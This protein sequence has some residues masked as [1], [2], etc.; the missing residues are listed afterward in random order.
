MK[1][2][3]YIVSF[4]L[5]TSCSMNDRHKIQASLQYQLEYYPASRL[6]D[7]YKNFFQDFYGPGHLVENPQASLDYLKDELEEVGGCT[8]NKPVE[9][10]GYKNRFVRVDLCLIKNGRISFEEFSEL[11]LESARSFKI[12]NFESWEAEWKKILTEI[13]ELK[14]DIPGFQQDKVLLNEM[15]QRGEYVVHHSKEYIR[16]Y[17]PHYRIV[18]KDLLRDYS[19]AGK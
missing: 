14:V 3:L 15:L 2:T 11:F 18:R 17:D 16:E 6:T 8:M 7:I 12:P 10:T 9:E 13:E 5:I 4:I 19:W 1:I